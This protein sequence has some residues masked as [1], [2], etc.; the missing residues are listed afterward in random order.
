MRIIVS[1][2]FAEFCLNPYRCTHST[3]NSIQV[4]RNV[5]THISNRRFINCTLPSDNRKN[6]KKVAIQMAS[7]AKMYIFTA[8]G[9]ART[10]YAAVGRKDE[11]R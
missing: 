6:T 10:P 11:R 3:G 4:L 8:F 9:R 5:H 7:I 1:M 2:K